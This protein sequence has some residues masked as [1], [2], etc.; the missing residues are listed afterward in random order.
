MGNLPHWGSAHLQARPFQMPSSNQVE[1]QESRLLSDLGSPSV[2]ASS[3][4]GMN[5]IGPERVSAL[6]QS[7]PSRW[8]S[9]SHA[10]PWHCSVWRA[11]IQKASI[12]APPLSCF[13]GKGPSGCWEGGKPR[14]QLYSLKHPVPPVP[15]PASAHTA[16]TL[17]PESGRVGDVQREG[18]A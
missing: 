13:L 5:E 17:S 15:A 3:S 11:L 9:L 14:S 2:A 8:E 10:D 16:R 6:L 1:S 12:C 7:E 18:S 4:H